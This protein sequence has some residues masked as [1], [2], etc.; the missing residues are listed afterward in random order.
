MHALD[1]L[2]HELQDLNREQKQAADDIT[3]IL[4]ELEKA[5]ASLYITEE[6]THTDLENKEIE[7]GNCYIQLDRSKLKQKS[8]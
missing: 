7:R 1:S 6:N 5:L 2:T 4:V 8:P 3:D